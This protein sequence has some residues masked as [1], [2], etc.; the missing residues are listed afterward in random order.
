MCVLIAVFQILSINMQ[1]LAAF[2]KLLYPSYQLNGSGENNS[3][4]RSDPLYDAAD[5]GEQADIIQRTQQAKSD[6]RRRM[7]R[8][9]AGVAGPVNSSSAKGGTVSSRGVSSSQPTRNAPRAK[10][11]RSSGNS[12]SRSDTQ[13]ISQSSPSFP[14]SPAFVL[15][16]R[17]IQRDE[18]DE[19]E[20]EGRSPATTLSSNSSRQDEAPKTSSGTVKRSRI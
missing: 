1:D 18:E 2:S 17:K 7:S 16:S 11:I 13:A 4:H 8:T 9:S 10:E 14:K 5:A 3:L 19:D 20:E 6:E 12:G 15:N